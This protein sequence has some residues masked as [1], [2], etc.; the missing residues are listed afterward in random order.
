MALTPGSSPP[1][2]KRKRTEVADS[3]SEDGASLDGDNF[4]W[5]EDDALALD[6]AL[7]DEAVIAEQDHQPPEDRLEAEAT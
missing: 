7:D 4:D 2:L 5:V 1:K 3:E 6:D